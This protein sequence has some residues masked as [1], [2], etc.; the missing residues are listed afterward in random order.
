MHVRMYACMRTYIYVCMCESMH[1]S[2]HVCMY[3]CMH[4]Y[5]YVCMYE[6]MHVCMYRNIQIIDITYNVTTHMHAQPHIHIY[7][8]TH[9]SEC[10]PARNQ[11]PKDPGCMMSQLKTCMDTCPYICIHIHTYVFISI[12]MYTYPYI[13]STSPYTCED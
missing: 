2:M 6:S 5:I 4:T 11:Y 1:E 12:H 13:L 10:I 3:A 7:I 8:S 9:T